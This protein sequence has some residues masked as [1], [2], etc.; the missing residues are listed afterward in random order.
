MTNTQ[1]ILYVSNRSQSSF[2]HADANTCY[3]MLQIEVAT[4]RDHGKPSQ[5]ADAEGNFRIAVTARCSIK[6]TGTL[7]SDS[8]SYTVQLTSSFVHNS[9]EIREIATQY[10]KAER[11]KAKLSKVVGTDLSSTQAC[12]CEIKALFGD[13]PI[14]HKNAK[15]EIIPYNGTVSD[16][17][18]YLKSSVNYASHNKRRERLEKAKG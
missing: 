16:L 1:T 12:L 9:A 4:L 6:D 2:D 5:W 3:E 13:F 8:L 7:A 18:S 10:A 15:D 17:L 11:A 14:Y